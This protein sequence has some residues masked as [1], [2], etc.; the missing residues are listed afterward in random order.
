MN[1]KELEVMI[2]NLNGNSSNEEILLVRG[3]IK[4]AL[5][6]GNISVNEYSKLGLFLNDTVMPSILRAIRKNKVLRKQRELLRK[7][8]EL[9]KKQNELLVEENTI[10]DKLNKIIEVLTKSLISND[11]DESC[12]SNIIINFLTGCY[13][14]DFVRIVEIDSAFKSINEES[15]ELEIK[16]KDESV[17]DTSK[18]KLS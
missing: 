12:I 7:Q 9:L 5:K 11:V 18:L 4:E 3:K 16:L 13:G 6:M 1:Y 8:N 14:E 10:L 2:K 15:A 17:E